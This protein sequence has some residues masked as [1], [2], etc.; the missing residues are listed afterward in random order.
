MNIYLL[1][2]FNAIYSI[3]I[4]LILDLSISQDYINPSKASLVAIS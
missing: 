1:A 2:Y 3:K 4:S